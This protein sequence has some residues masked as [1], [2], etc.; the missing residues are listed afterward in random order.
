MSS[1]PY[2]IEIRFLIQATTWPRTPNPLTITQGYLS[3]DPSRT[4]R[5]RVVDN[6]SAFLTIK[7]PT[8]GATRLEFEY[9]I[10][11]A[12]AHSLLEMCECRVTKLRHAI[13]MGRWTW[14]VDEFLDRNAGLVIAEVELEQESEADQIRRSRPE[15]A[16]PEL[17]GLHEYSNLNLS[18][19][20]YAEWTLEE[21]K[22]RVASA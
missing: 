14:E 22:L 8:E 1:D 2:E 15:W 11:A 17:T 4:V 20:P 3:I 6:G 19:H 12:H 7:G 16:G 5:V 21:R 18:Q 10:P 9:A 13:P